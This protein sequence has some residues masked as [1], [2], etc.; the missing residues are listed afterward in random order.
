[1]KANRLMIAVGMLMFIAAIGAGCSRDSA[2]QPSI[3]DAVLY[4]VA[5]EGGQVQFTAQVQT[6]DEV[7]RKLT[8]KER[9][10]TV[11]AY[12]NCEVVRLQNGQESPANFG[13]ICPGDTLRVT[14]D[15]RQ[16]GYVYAYR[17]GIQYETPENYQFAA[18]VQ[19]TDQ[20]CMMIMFQG[21]P[22]TVIAQQQCEFARHC[23][24]FQF[25]VEFSDIK[26]GDSVQVNGE[27]RQ[28]GYLYAQRIE[29]RADDPGGRWDVSFKDTITSID[30]T[31]GTFMVAGRTELIT[32]DADTK[33][34]G[35]IVT[36]QEPIDNG[37]TGGG[38][39]ALGYPNQWG[40]TCTDTALAFTDLTVGDMVTVHAVF[41]DETSLLAT[42]IRLTDC[43][44]ISKKCV[45]FVAPLATVDP[46]TRIVT[47]VAQSW[48]GEVC[49]GAQLIGLDGEELTLAD[50]AAGETVSVKGF[51]VTEDTLRI[52]KMEKVPTPF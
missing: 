37:R 31:L 44:E 27:R 13:E 32:I 16:G 10:E 41:V 8:F 4:T 2:T 30:Y 38:G 17:L 24:G 12:E 19:T 35:S 15:R 3:G 9:P 45:E 6:R 36:Y 1:M 22:D 21:R 52:S 39:A 43:E 18:R 28:D 50:F 46:D 33:I 47:F 20:N 5:D 48:T 49:N 26:P 42:C 34:L 7:Q 25:Q 29:I 23:F 40:K 14:G 51:P 11:I